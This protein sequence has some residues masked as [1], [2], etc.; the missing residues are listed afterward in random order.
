MLENVTI[1]ASAFL[2]LFATG[3]L[4]YHKLHVRAELSRK[5]VHLF[6]G[7]LTFTLP[8]LIGDHRIVFGLCMSFAGLLYLSKRYGFLKSINAIDRPSQ[9]SL[10]YPLVI[11]LCYYVYHLSNEYIY[12]YLPILVLAIADPLAAL[13]GKKWPKGEYVIGC[14]CKTITGSSVFFV[15]AFIIS[16][17]LLLGLTSVSLFSALII[18]LVISFVTTIAEALSRNGLDNF[19][20]PIAALVI[21][22]GIE[23]FTIFL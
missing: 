3:E 20:I 22:I 9:G 6:T 13:S 7:I 21:L 23:R 11:Y 14:H 5:F 8:L 10:W 17:T 12:F 2:S 4:L 19:T 16:I 1:V 18:G 15:S